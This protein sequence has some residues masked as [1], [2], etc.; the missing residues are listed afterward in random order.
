MDGWRKRGFGESGGERVYFCFEMFFYIGIWGV[1]CLE[2]Y[3]MVFM[4]V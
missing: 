1:G 2:F 3:G 4:K